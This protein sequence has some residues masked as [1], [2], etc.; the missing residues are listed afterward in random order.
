MGQ[1]NDINIGDLGLDDPSLSSWD[2]KTRDLVPAGEYVLEIADIKVGQ[3]KKGNN[4]IEVEW[5]VVSEGDAYGKSFRQWY[6]TGQTGNAKSDSVNKRRLKHVFIDCL[7]VTLLPGGGFSTGDCMG[8]RL[9]GEVTHESRTE[10]SVQRNQEVEYVN[11]RLAGER[12]L[13]VVEEQAPPQRAQPQTQ[14][15]QPDARNGNG[16]TRTRTPVASRQSAAK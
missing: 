6:S 14:P 10:F 4:T 16:Q 12:P 2:G 8:R 7:G 11:E 1:F 9:I 15:V 3:S 13:E 5:K